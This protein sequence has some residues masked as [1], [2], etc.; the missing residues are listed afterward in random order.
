V[1]GGLPTVDHASFLVRLDFR[2][3]LVWVVTL[4][5]IAFLWDSPIANLALVVSLLGL[6]A[7]ARVR[8]SYLWLIAKIMAPFYVLVLVTHGFWNV[9]Q[10]KVLSGH[11]ALTPLVTLPRGLPLV[12]GASASVEGVL[13]G[14]SVIAKTLALILVVPL[15]IFTTEV[16]RMIAGMVR[17]R[18]PY[19]VT[20]IFSSTL[21]FFPVLFQEIQ[22]IIEAQR[23]RGL[24]LEKMGPIRRV[25]IYARIAV[26][27]IL[28]ALVRAQQ[29]EVVLQGKAFSGSRDRTYLHDAS[30]GRIDWALIAIGVA[31][32]P[33]VGVLY[34]GYGVGRFGWLS[35]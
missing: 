14:V 2:T 28:G 16:D 32:L 20:F 30:L 18:I 27:L 25:R 8:G 12:G 26:P 11:A 23:L 29:L 10:V 3:K 1:I 15:A 31:V 7:V 22:T 17:A 19:K 6:C 21:R 4:T 13:Y 24:A 34:V 9:D 33:V 5:I 35:S